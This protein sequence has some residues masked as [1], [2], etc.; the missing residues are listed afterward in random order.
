M[1]LAERGVIVTDETSRHWCQE[2]GQQFANA[3]RRRRPRPGDKWHLDGLC[4]TASPDC[5]VVADLVMVTAGVTA[6]VARCSHG[7]PWP[8]PAFVAG[9][10]TVFGA[11]SKKPVI[12]VSRPSAPKH[13]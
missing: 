10:K 13:T 3:L 6:G 5:A 4:S 2:F 1:P 9:A 12:C 11:G 8:Q 7:E